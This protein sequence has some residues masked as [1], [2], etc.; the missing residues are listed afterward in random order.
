MYEED[1]D[2]DT[3]SLKSDDVWVISVEAQASLLVVLWVRLKQARMQGLRLSYLA[4]PDWIHPLSTGCMMMIS[5]FNRGKWLSE[6][7]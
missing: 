1:I 3:I 6:R 7:E 5:H 2:S 4:E